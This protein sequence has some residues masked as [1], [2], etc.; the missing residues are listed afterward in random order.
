M[1]RSFLLLALALFGVALAD[2]EIVNVRVP[3]PPSTL[4]LAEL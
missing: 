2:T 3:L 1:L 4:P